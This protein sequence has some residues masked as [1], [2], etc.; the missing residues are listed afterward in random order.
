[1]KSSGLFVITSVYHILLSILLIEERKLKNN[2]LVIVEITPDIES[3][4]DS[5]KQSPWFND[6]I[7]LIG[8][9]KQKKL[10]GKLCYTFNRKHIV[11]LIDKTNLKLKSLPNQNNSFDV[12]I[13]SPD[14][15]KNYFIYKYK[16]H[17]IF[18]IE[19]GLKT[20]VSQSPSFF[21]QLYA[22]LINRPLVN[23]YDR[24]I[25]KVFATSP[26]ELPPL[27]KSKS[28][29]LDW[30]N[31]FK[32]LNKVKLNTLATAFSPNKQLVTNSLFPEG[33]TKSIILTQTLNED[34]VIEEESEKINIYTSFVKQAKTDLI[35]IKPHPRERT[36][37]NTLFAE[38]KHIIVLPKLFPAELLN[39]YP[40]LKFKM[41]FT[42]FSTAID[43][44]EHVEEKIS[45]GHAKFKR[46]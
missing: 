22:K 4:K 18:M 33:K 16:D 6:V 25:Q 9:K 31:T 2:I 21:K 36:D 3:L 10:A 42:A 38:H 32:Q 39:M 28:E 20:Y 17:N 11:K 27:L 40:N 43:H 46:K 37:Y 24:R 45:L 41:A 1:M 12:Y 26:K 5:L 19:D 8:R 30:K 13:C 7:L 44:L 15:A 34:G 14:S 29:K 35:Y 23:G